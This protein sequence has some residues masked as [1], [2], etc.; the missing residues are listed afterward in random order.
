MNYQQIKK[1]TEQLRLQQDYWNNK[2]QSL[3]EGKLLCSRDK[4]NFKYYHKI[5]NKK[6]YLDKSKQKLA[7]QLAVKSYIHALLKDISHE[8]T[9]N[10]FYLRH[11][12]DKSFVESLLNH[13]GIQRLLNPYF[14]PHSK[15]LAEWMSSPYTHNPY[16]PEHLSHKTVL[17]FLVRSKSESM[18]TMMLHTNNIPFR[19][20]CELVLGSQIIYPDFT[21]RHPQTGECYYWEHLGKMDDPNY[22]KNKFRLL[23]QYTSHGIVP[24]IN[25]I[26]TFETQRHPL[27]AD[28][29]QKIIEHY[30]L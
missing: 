29:I 7:E 24:S 20:E 9:A 6:V 13:P 2:L 23:E 14:K 18:I 5:S 4:N 26:L 16:Y 25:L 11:Y 15:E 17:N 10:Q 22:Y 21:I 1:R 27:T 28:V 30:F 19:Y 3:P 8:L 12:A